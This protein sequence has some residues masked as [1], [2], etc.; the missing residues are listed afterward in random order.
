MAQEKLWVRGE[1]ETGILTHEM[2]SKLRAIL[3]TL[4]S[5]KVSEKY[6]CTI[7]KTRT[8]LTLKTGLSVAYL[9]TLYHISIFR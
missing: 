3:M 1:E 6:L 5:E 7:V 2:E 9:M 8:V 4:C